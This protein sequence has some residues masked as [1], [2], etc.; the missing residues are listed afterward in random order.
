M[1]GGHS[2]LVHNGQA[3]TDR[4]Q[5]DATVRPTAPPLNVEDPARSPSTLAPGEGKPARY[6]GATGPGGTEANVTAT[7]APGQRTAAPGPTG[8][9]TF[10]SEGGSVV[11][12][13][14]D[15]LAYLDSWHPAPG[16][17]VDRVERGPADKV[18]IRFHSP[19]VAA[20]I[21]VRC[22]DSEPLARAESASRAGPPS[23]RSAARRLRPD[24]IKVGCGRLGGEVVPM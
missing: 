17:A 15:T 24:A 6:P 2:V 14:Y 12:A 20:T 13:C 23:Q 5:T 10:T 3:R 16:H 1:C 8:W 4:P 21:S 18:R 9:A 19:S 22:M 11:A 7:A